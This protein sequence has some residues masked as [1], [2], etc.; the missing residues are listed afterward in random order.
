MRSTLS[1]PSRS[2]HAFVKVFESE[3]YGCPV[4]NTSKFIDVATK[5]TLSDEVNS[6]L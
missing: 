6:K 1:S 3:G 2:A 5:L 4:M